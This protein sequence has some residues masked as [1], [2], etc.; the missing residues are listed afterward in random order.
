MDS[1]F[2]TSIHPLY[3]ELLIV[4]RLKIVLYSPWWVLL[5]PLRTKPYTSGHVWIRRPGFEDGHGGIRG[6]EELTDDDDDE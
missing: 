6:G 1:T 4:L 2:L 3:G 5:T